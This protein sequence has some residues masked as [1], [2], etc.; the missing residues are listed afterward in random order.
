MFVCGFRG[1]LRKA[2]DTAADEAV[3]KQTDRRSPGFAAPG[4]PAIDDGVW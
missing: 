1:E 4:L 2:V 3:D